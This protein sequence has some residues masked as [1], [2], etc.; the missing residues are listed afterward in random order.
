[1]GKQYVQPLDKWELKFL[2][3]LGQTVQLEYMFQPHDQMLKQ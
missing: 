2:S 1:M 3:R